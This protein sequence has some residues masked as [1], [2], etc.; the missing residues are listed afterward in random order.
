MIWIMAVFA[1]SLASAV[2]T[3]EQYVFIYPFESTLL[4]WPVN[5]NQVLSNLTLN[6]ESAAIPT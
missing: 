3:K 1:L 5:G 2:N 4:G 6:F